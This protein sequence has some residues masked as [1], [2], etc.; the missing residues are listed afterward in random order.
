MNLDD[1]LELARSRRSTRKF[2]AEP[3]PEGVVGKVLDAARWAQSGANAQPWEFLVVKDKTTINKMADI[4]EYWMA[5]TVWP[6]EKSRTKEIRHRMFVD[7]IEDAKSGWRDAPVVVVMLGDPRTTQS[8]V[9]VSQYLP[10]EGGTGAH[11][12]KN[13]ANATQ[14]IQLAVAAAGL[15]SEWVSISYAV[16]RKLK[17]LLG[18]PDELII[19]TMVP[20]GHPAGPAKPGV[21]RDINEIIHYEKYDMSKARSAEDIYQYLLALRTR[22]QPAYKKQG[23]G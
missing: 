10:H 7:G 17:E 18:V 21:R 12:L 3:I 8:S 4:I 11:S 1:F 13:M 9:L 2:T 15:G 16:E 6:I 23:Q 19:H 22:T 20:I 14:I 5:N